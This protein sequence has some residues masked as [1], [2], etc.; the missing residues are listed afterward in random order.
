MFC[1]SWGKKLGKCEH[2]CSKKKSE[3]A[4]S[5]LTKLIG[6]QYI[7]SFFFFLQKAIDTGCKKKMKSVFQGTTPTNDTRFMLWL[8]HSHLKLTQA[9]KSL[10]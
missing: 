7:S 8:M 6:Q 4:I 1:L 3:K 2:L 10:F 5:V 9:Y